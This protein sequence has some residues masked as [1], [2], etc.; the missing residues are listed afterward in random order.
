MRRLILALLVSSAMLSPACREPRGRVEL[1]PFP[2]DTDLAP[3]IRAQVAAR[4]G[5]AVLMYEGASWCEPCNR[6]HEAARAGRLDAEFPTLT[7]LELDADLDGE[8]LASAGYFSEL[9]PLFA[10]P[11]ADGRASGVQIEGG[12]KGDGAVDNVVTRLRPLIVQA[13]RNTQ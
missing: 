2:A 11:A 1:V 3:W 12:I 5:R 6:F 4:P 9:I 10:V 8:K 7:L 13:T